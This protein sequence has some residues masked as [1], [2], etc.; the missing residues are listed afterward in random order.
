MPYK[1][2]D[3]VKIYEDPL[4]EKKLEG[5]AK[6]IQQLSEDVDREF[7]LVEMTRGHERHPRWIKKETEHRYPPQRAGGS[8]LAWGWCEKLQPIIDDEEKGISVYDELIG[9]IRQ[10]VNG[11]NPALEI[12][13]FSEKSVLEN[14]VRTLTRIVEEQR[15]HLRLV[16]AL[17]EYI[18]P[19]TP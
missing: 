9:E 2:G 14:A 8:Y 3:I 1:V 7:W 12:H 10:T 17:K 18:C 6:L 4:T 11:I 15:N 19:S 5:E 16:K 13:G